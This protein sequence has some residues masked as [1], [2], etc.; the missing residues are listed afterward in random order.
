MAEAQDKLADADDKLREV[1]ERDRFRHVC[2]LFWLRPTYVS[3][4][5]RAGAVGEFAISNCEL[6]GGRVSCRR[7]RG[8]LTHAARAGRQH[9][10]VP[11][12]DAA[13]ARVRS[14]A[15]EVQAGG[16]ATF[17][18]LAGVAGEPLSAAAGA[19]ESAKFKSDSKFKFKSDSEL[20]AGCAG[21]AGAEGA[22]G[23]GPPDGAGRLQ[24]RPPRCARAPRRRPGGSK[25]LVIESLWSQFSSTCQRL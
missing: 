4:R 22:G 9:A 25:G 12:A 1:G 14:R 3:G 24:G 2:G 7:L 8:R 13:D 20:S 19:R 11:R 21:A 18:V 10:R 5:C 16:A 17:R 23:G 6:C 15:R